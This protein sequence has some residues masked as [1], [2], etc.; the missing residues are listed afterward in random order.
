[1][2]ASRLKNSN[3]PVYNEYFVEVHLAIAAGRCRPMF[4]DALGISNR[5]PRTPG[6]FQ[7]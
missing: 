4:M 1:M 6:Q 5:L 7:Y 3:R 2:W